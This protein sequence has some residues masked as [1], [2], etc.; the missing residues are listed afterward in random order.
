LELQ[1]AE[2]GTALAENCTEALASA[3]SRAKSTSDSNPQAL[4][5]GQTTGVVWR[6]LVV[7]TEELL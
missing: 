7:G 3:L 4:Y 1:V 5:R 2:E 6:A